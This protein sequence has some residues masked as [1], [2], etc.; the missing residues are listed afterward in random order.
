MKMAN[1]IWKVGGGKQKGPHICGKEEE[2]TLEN[3]KC[4][5]EM[6]CYRVED[7]NSII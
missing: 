7:V 1:Q 2:M 6:H 3:R 4:V 5:E